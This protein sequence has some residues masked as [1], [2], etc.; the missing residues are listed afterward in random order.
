MAVSDIL[1]TKAKVYY[2]AFGTSFPSETDVDFDGSWGGSWTALGETLTPVVWNASISEFPVDVQSTPLPIKTFVDSESHTFTFTL[3]EM[4]GDNL[5]LVMHGTNTDTSAGA[6]QKGYSKIQIGGKRTV[7]LYAVGFEGYREE[8]STGT[9]QPVRIHVF[10]AAI[11]IAGSVPMDKRSVMGIPLMVT[12]YADLTSHSTEGQQAIEMH[13][14]T[15]S[16]TA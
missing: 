1:S 7:T 6:T 8:A 5:A 11:T 13:V 4:T 15:S 10:N 2:A 14:V 3:A 9:L 16:V 12:T